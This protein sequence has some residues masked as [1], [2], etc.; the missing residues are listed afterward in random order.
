M[1]FTRNQII[2]YVYNSEPVISFYRSAMG[3]GFWPDIPDYQIE[4][5]AWYL[6]GAEVNEITTID[7][8]LSEHKESLSR[9]IAHIYANGK[10]PWRVTPGFLCAL[11]LIV[12]FPGP[13]TEDHLVEKGWEKELASIVISSAKI[14]SPYLA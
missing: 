12:K 11:V 5:L 1:K 3:I 13:F 9:Y 6:D 10:Q 8:L 14:F 4:E 7:S 2:D